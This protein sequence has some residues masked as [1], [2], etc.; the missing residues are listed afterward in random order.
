MEER[1]R[2]RERAG[3]GSERRPGR[4]PWQEP[5]A[6]YGGVGRAGRW[7]REREREREREIASVDGKEREPQSMEERESL[8]RWKRE[9]ASVDGRERERERERGRE[10]GEKL[11]SPV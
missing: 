8:S 3:C 5:M 4:W 1:D 2:E 7:K 6:R 10:G 11:G 9:R